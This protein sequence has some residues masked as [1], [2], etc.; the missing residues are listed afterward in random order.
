MSRRQQSPILSLLVVAFT[1]I[2]F[3]LSFTFSQVFG[4]A[5]AD[6]AVTWAAQMSGST[7]EAVI[8]FVSFYVVPA[9]MAGMCMWATFLIALWYLRLTEFS[10]DS[11]A[12][13]FSLRSMT[14]TEIAEYLRDQSVWGWQTY[15]KLNG[16]VHDLVGYEMTRAARAGDVRFIGTPPNSVT[17]ILIDLPYWH[18]CHIDQDRV[19]DSR[20]EFFTNDRGFGSGQRLVHLRFGRAPRLHVVR[21]WPRATVFRKTISRGFVCIKKLWWRFKYAMHSG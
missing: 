6:K 5:V 9:F 12:P 13:V 16:F 20:N 21:T 18:M 17:E 14:V 1:V 4:N 8:Q 19:W 11:N 3:V 15:A 10:E 2:F 7:N